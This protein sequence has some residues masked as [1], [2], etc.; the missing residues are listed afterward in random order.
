MGTG[1]SPFKSYRDSL[2]NLWKCSNLDES[3]SEFSASRTT[4][5]FI[6]SVKFQDDR[7]GK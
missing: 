7:V 4:Y 5:I 3:G 2:T 6:S 1:E